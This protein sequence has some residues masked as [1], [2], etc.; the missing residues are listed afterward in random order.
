VKIHFQTLGE[1]QKFSPTF[2][3]AVYR[4]VQ[5]LVHNI[6]K[7]ARASEALIQM[8]FGGE[9]FDLSI[10]DNGIGIPDNIIKKSNGMGLKSIEDRLKAIN[11]KMTIQNIAGGG[12]GIYLEISLQ[13]EN[14]LSS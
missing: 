12:T 14:I 11:G 8:G 13:K 9:M 5:E 10:E 7:H 4:V 3:L 6:L 1:L 2:E